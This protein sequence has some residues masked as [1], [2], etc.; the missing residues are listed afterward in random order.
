MKWVVDNSGRFGWRPYYDRTELDSECEQIVADFL[1]HKY[2]AIRFPVTT[3]DLAVMIE[4]DTSDLDLYADLSCD[5]EDV[6]GTTDFFPHK[7]PAVKIAQE[8]SLDSSRY[9]RLRT[10]LA[11]E[12]GHVKF[13]N[14][15]WGMTAP[16]KPP[17][18]MMKKLSSQRQAM[19]RLRQK[20]NQKPLNDSD[21]E[22]MPKLLTSQRT[23]K[24]VR[25]LI[26]QAP[27]SDWMEW[28]ASYVCGA[29]LMPLSAVLKMVEA[30]EPDRNGADRMP[31][32]S[33]QARE[34][35]NRVAQAFDV[36]PDAAQ[37]RLVKTGILQK[38]PPE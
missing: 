11:H 17:A 1:M 22:E 15:L 6:E 29:L 38:V 34:I 8:L 5:G 28:Q 35:I 27:V 23:F 14:F 21:R 20:I 36:S 25:G 3:D 4:R 31:A 13:H 33:A 16:P 19:S 12:Y 26:L 7:K 32:D 10:T 37:V 2:G 30:K 18:N 9:L 24:C